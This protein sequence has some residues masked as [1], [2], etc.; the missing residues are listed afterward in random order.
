MSDQWQA[1][2]HE[3]LAANFE[4]EGGASRPGVDW[5][6]S[7]KDG[8]DD[9]KLMVRM[10]FDVDVSEE[11]KSDQDYQCRTTVQYLFDQIDHGWHPREECEHVIVLRDPVS[12]E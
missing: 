8:D 6:I 5:S 7:L 12:E 3:G 9:Y 10:L 4:M 1:M 2:I 11:T